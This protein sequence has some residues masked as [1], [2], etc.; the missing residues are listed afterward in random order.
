MAATSP[1]AVAISASAMPGATTP[2]L[3][4]PVAPIPWNAIM[5]PHD[6]AEQTDERRDARRRRQKRH[7]LLEL[8][9]F[10]DRRAHQRAIH[11]GQALQGWTVGRGLRIGH[12]VSAASALTGGAAP[13]APRSR[14]GTDRPAGCRRATGRPPGLRRTCCCAETRRGNCAD[15]RCDAAKHPQLVENDAPGHDRKQR[16]DQRGRPW[17]NGR[18]AG[19]Q[20][21][22]R[23][24]R[25]L[26]ETHSTALRLQQQGKERAS[27]RA[28][29]A[30]RRH[31]CAPLGQRA[32]GE[33]PG[34][35]SVPNCSTL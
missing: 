18:R 24:A 33:S 11:R 12:R 10:D 32:G 4:E 14:P 28:Q 16:Q 25:V 8:V 6:R 19:D 35:G 26:F 5:M 17:R 20:V 1:T 2:R 22:D 34:L 27:K 7:A 15:C 29:T 23:R 13:S 9:H 31:S 30:L 3:V 21:D